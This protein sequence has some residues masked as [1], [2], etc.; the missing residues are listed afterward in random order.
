M[1]RTKGFR[2][3]KKSVSRLDQRTRG[4]IKKKFKNGIEVEGS[5]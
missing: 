3:L 4:S 5:F 2:D 1:I